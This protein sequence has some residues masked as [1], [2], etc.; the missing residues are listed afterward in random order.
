[1]AQNSLSPLHW[2][3]KVDG[4][5]I[6]STILD[7]LTKITVESSLNIPA[8]AALYLNPPPLNHDPLSWIDTVQFDPGK[9]L[10]IS[11]GEGATITALFDGEIVELEPS[12]GSDGNRLVVRAFDLLHRLSRGRKV[13]SFANM[14]DK[15]II[16]AVLSNHQMTF[17]YSN[18][19]GPGQV[20]EQVMQ[21]SQT[22]LDFVRTRAAT[23]GCHC[24]AVGAKVH[25]VAPVQQTAVLMIDQSSLLSFR[26]RLTTTDQVSKVTVRGWKEKTKEDV[27][28]TFE[29]SGVKNTVKVSGKNGAAFAAAAPG[30]GQEHLV[31]DWVVDDQAQAQ[32][33]AEALATSVSGRFV[34]A[35]GITYGAPQIVAGAW[36]E[37]KNVGRYSGTYFVTNALHHFDARSGYET[38]YTISGHDPT[39]LLHLLSSES[40]DAARTGLQVGVVTE[41]DPKLAKAKV[42]LPHLG[43]TAVTNWARIAAV[44][45]GANRGIQ[46][47]PEVGDEVIIGF[48]RGDVN[49]PFILGGLWNGTDTPPTQVALESTKVAARVI[50]SRTGHVITF[51]D[52]EDGGAITIKDKAGGTITLS[53]KDKSITIESKKDIIVKATGDLTMSGI[54]LS[55]QGTKGVDIKGPQVK[56]N[57]D[58]QV[59]IKGGLVKI[60]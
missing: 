11:V 23:I 38:E 3:V 43:D 54:N 20:H 32:Y 60:N 39:T 8:V 10:T 53:A 26:P 14:T 6:S 1:M 30:G 28:G 18:S 57:G 22:D 46:F 31:T 15:D 35:E 25:C 9:K 50:Q 52:K 12:F 4:Q 34:Q 29:G 21:N 33:I 58:A 48:D 7:C 51:E 37:I 45:A 40:N 44:G 56:I 36:I 24:F 2:Y 19:K 59:E 42:R 55:I 16:S 13:K 5:E 47:L 41:V 27:V 17:N 49:F